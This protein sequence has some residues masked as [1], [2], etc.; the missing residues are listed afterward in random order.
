MTK[1]ARDLIREYLAYMQV[2]KGLSA[3]SI[4][5]YRRDLAKLKLWASSNNIEPQ[6]LTKKEAAAWIRSLTTA[7]LSPRSVARA[8]S[9]AKGF[10]RF[11]LLDGHIKCDPFGDV[12]VPQSA[13]SIPRFLN[14]EEM[15]RLLSAPDVE[16][17]EGVRDRAMLELLYATGLRVSE[18]VGLPVG[19]VD[20]MQGVL[21][22]TGKGNKHRRIPVGRSALSWLSAYIPAREKLLDGRESKTLFIRTGG[23]SLTRHYFWATLRA[24]ALACGVNDVS[25]HVLRHSFATHLMQRGADSRSVQ[26]LLGHSDIG[27]TQIYT[28][29][30]GARLR[31]TYDEHHPRA[32]VR[33]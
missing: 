33:V 22:C 10:C 3:N 29:I 14:E 19:S 27:T 7:G 30:T 6:N 9:G 32:K 12:V 11:L 18:L 23:R 13:Q 31:S 15:E 25:P 21:E 5:S 17:L 4:A 1:I 20:P 8:V 2:E 28:H 26:S 16:C 24:Y